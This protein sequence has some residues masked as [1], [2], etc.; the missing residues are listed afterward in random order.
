MGIADA[1]G[2]V[3]GFVAESFILTWRSAWRL[4]ATG[5]FG[6]ALGCLVGACATS[7]TG[8]GLSAQAKASRGS[9]AKQR[10]EAAS[11]VLGSGF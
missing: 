2:A 9:A 1:M 7:P 6:L 10:V 4:I 11:T 3:M 8:E 5:L